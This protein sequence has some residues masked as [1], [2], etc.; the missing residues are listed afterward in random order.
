MDQQLHRRSAT[1]CI[2]FH[3]FYSSQSAHCSITIDEIPQQLH[4]HL[5][6]QSN[7]LARTTHYKL[8]P[9]EKITTNGLEGYFID[10]QHTFINQRQKNPM[11]KSATISFALT[12]MSGKNYS[13]IFNRQRMKKN[14]HCT[15]TIRGM[16]A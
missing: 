10:Q 7:H 16:N 9:K 12:K 2:C 6:H 15:A 14:Q 8:F 11:I 1:A 13:M 4:T 5:H 3:P